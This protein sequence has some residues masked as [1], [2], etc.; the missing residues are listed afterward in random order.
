M[1][2]AAW[3]AD[4]KPGDRAVTTSL[5]HA[6]TLAPLW[7]LR[8]RLGVDL[9]VAD[10]GLGGDQAAVLAAMERGNHPGQLGSWRS[11]TCR[12]PP[13]RDCPYARSRSWRTRAERSLPWT[14]RNR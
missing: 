5:E 14:G 6:G 8:E 9:A 12:G 10:I 2:V 13:A 11:R 3:A 4:W 7:A 1:N